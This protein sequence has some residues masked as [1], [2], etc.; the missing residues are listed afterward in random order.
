MPTLRSS[1]KAAVPA[2]L[3]VL[4]LALPAQAR[5][6]SVVEEKGR[7][8]LV[9]A[10]GKRR[11]LTSSA[12]DSQPRLSPDGKAV[13]FVRDV[14]GKKVESATGEVEANEVWWVDTAG[15]K[16]R[17]LVASA[18]S[19]DP[20]TFLGALQDP[21]FSPDG[22]SVFFLSAAWATSGAVH[23]VDVATGKEQFVTPGNSLEVILRGEHQGKLI[24][25]QHKYFLG[26]GSYDWFWLLEPDGKQVG[27]I[28]DDVSRFRELYLQ[29]PAS[30]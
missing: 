15:G 28:G 6:P 24:V 3:A 29:E 23:K 26:G 7:I 9:E 1:M 22:K 8:V 20:K 25:Q 2:L 10:N 30:P 16:P 27:P 4:L 5:G 11:P 18:A 13:V 19:D 21:Q 14:S 12:Q 17:R